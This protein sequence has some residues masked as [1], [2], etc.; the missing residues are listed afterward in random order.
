MEKNINEN[1]KN[2]HNTHDLNLFAEYTCAICL[3]IIVEPIETAC[4]HIF[5]FYCI[6][7]MKESFTE[8]S[9]FKCPLCREILNK[10]TN[11]EIDKDLDN[12]I[13][14]S[15]PK[16]YSE[17]YKVLEINKKLNSCYLKIKILFGNKHKLVEK[18]T[19][20]HS[21]PNSQN[22]HEWTAFVK[23]EKNIEENKLIEK[24]EF[25]LH[26]TFRN[27]LIE[28]KYPPYS[29]TCV[30]WGV[31]EIPIKIYWKDFL[32]ME[33]TEITHFLCFDQDIKMDCKIIK[34]DK[35]ILEAKK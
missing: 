25:R 15:F 7:E 16:E 27:N 5:C 2:Q 9:Q 19:D 13:K 8:N 23:L 3:Q 33:P 35:N 20:S 12:K 30:G 31:F 29:F 24:V 1:E 11:Y 17:K 21:N 4:N 14:E 28:K 6:E 18:P 22:N 34:I 10:N 32:K 26:H